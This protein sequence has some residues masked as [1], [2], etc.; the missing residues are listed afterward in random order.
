MRI[1]ADDGVGAMCVLRARPFPPLPLSG[2]RRPV[3]RIFGCVYFRVC[4]VCRILF[5]LCVFDFNVCG[6]A[7]NVVKVSVFLPYL[8]RP[9][10][11]YRECPRGGGW[12]FRQKGGAVYG[13]THPAPRVYLKLTRRGEIQTP[14]TVSEVRCA[15]S[16][17]AALNRRIGVDRDQLDLVQQAR[18]W[19]HATLRQ[20]LAPKPEHLG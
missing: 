1:N 18:I 5:T 19:W 12:F 10:R 13:F 9:T 14:N 15:F 2:D 11:E 4:A 16:S 6:K 17:L 8:K 7:L 20:P 3:R